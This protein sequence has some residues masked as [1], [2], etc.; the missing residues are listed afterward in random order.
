MKVSELYQEI[1]PFFSNLEAKRS[2][3]TLRNY[4]S[5]VES[6]LKSSDVN[7]EFNSDSIRKWLRLIGVQPRTRSRKLSALRSFAK[8]LK[9]IGLLENDPTEFIENPYRRKHL[10]KALN[11]PEVTAILDQEGIGKTP[12]RDRAMLETLYSTGIRC[13]E[14]VAICIFH[15]DFNQHSIRV[16]GKGNRDR[17]VLMTST[18]E[19]AI[20]DYL[21]SE[22]IVG[23]TSNYQ[24]QPLFTNYKGSRITTRTVQNV[25]MRWRITAGIE[26]STT[27]HVFRHSFATHLLD[28]GANL[29]T[30]QQ[31]LGHE[32]LETTQI[33]THV[34]VDRLRSAVQSAHP[35]GKVK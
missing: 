25:V 7:S 1:E 29:K 35:K 31:L 3:H 24:N 14:L 2:V 22:R 10:P 32:S 19:A 21:E 5:D 27:P 33:Y 9:I 8:Y 20:R 4:R 26:K 11:E 16:R 34:S 18:C 12:L 23:Q 17:I 28:H 30:V 13:A 6:F 15:V